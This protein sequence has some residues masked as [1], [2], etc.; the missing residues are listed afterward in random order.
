MS[1]ENIK[2]VIEC[3]SSLDMSYGQRARSPDT[4]KVYLK[5]I[6]FVCT[7][8]AY[9]LISDRDYTEQ[10]NQRREYCEMVA[11]RAWPDYLGIFSEE[12]L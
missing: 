2:V 10:L 6:L 9:A 1:T 11:K 3:L 12:C 8:L 4:R 7:V 5:T